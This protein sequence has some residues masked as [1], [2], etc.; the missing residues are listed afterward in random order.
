LDRPPPR[1]PRLRHLPG[2]SWVAPAS[3]IRRKRHQNPFRFA[4]D[5]RGMLTGPW[6]FSHRD[7]SVPLGVPSSRSLRKGSRMWPQP[8]KPLPRRP[9]KVGPRGLTGFVHPGG[10]LPAGRPAH[11][12]VQPGGARTA[13]SRIRRAPARG[14]RADRLAWCVHPCPNGRSRELYSDWPGYRIA[15]RQKSNPGVGPVRRRAGGL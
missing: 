12:W 11:Q 7:D 15:A 1:R 6:S 3:A 9:Q 4:R 10:V 5:G 2:W 14:H 8:R 13:R